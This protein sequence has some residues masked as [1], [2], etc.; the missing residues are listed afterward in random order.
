MGAAGFHF[1]DLRDVDGRRSYFRP[2]TLPLV[3]HLLQRPVAR[4]QGVSSETIRDELLL[5]HSVFVCHPSWTNSDRTLLEL[6]NFRTVVPL[7]L[8]LKSLKP[9]SYFQV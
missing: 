6:T 7:S 8:G 2:I 4:K 5:Y 9:V 3:V 1:L